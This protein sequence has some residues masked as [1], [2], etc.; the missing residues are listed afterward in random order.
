MADKEMVVTVDRLATSALDEQVLTAWAQVLEVEPE[1]LS[2]DDDFEELG[3]NSILLML[4]GD[5]LSRSTGVEVSGPELFPYSTV[6][7]QIEYVRM[8]QADAGQ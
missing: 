5:Y 4:L 2:L 7:E 1:S 3:G 8:R 6:R